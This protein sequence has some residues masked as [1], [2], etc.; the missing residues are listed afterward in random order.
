MS[1]TQNTMNQPTQPPTYIIP[2]PASPNWKMPALVGVLLL[3]AASNVYLYMQLEHVKTDTKNDMAK[4]G[5]DLGQSI[6]QLRLDNNASLQASRHSAEVLQ[7]QLDRQRLIAQREVGAAKDDAEKKVQDLEQRVAAEQNKQAQLITQVKQTADTTSSKLTDVSSDVGTVK[8][9]L[10][11]TKSEL[12]TTISNLKRVNGDL[13]N[14]ASLIATNGKELAA[15]RALGERNY[16]EFTV[17][18]AKH[19]QRVGDI[20]LRLEK[21][22]LKK[23]RF[24]VEVTA[25][26]QVT[27]KRDRTLNEPIQFYTSKAKQPYEI[28]VNKIQKDTIVGYLS[29]P[30]VQNGR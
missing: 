23:N 14:H 26:D 25:D 27:E 19:P 24:T 5:N 4:L 17:P 28:V 20:S 15:L 30:K 1:T 2:P 18:K 22:D 9:D 16:I 10:S 21:V 6:T 8:T 11:N 7:Q 3:L 29:T 12:E 13:D